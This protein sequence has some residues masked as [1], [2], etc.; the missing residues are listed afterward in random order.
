M[1]MILPVFIF[2][3]SVV[4][5]A[6]SNRYDDG[7]YYDDDYIHEEEI[8]NDVK[9]NEPSDTY[10]PEAVQAPKKIVPVKKKKRKPAGGFEEVQSGGHVKGF[11]NITNDKLDSD[12]DQSESLGSH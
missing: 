6:E 11:Q 3:C 1:K 9:V 7:S 12:Y 4:A 8:V 2:L 10:V 5:L